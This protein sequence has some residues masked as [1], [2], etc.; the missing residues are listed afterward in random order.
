MMNNVVA[1]F[2]K[3]ERYFELSLC[4]VELDV[5]LPR[6]GCKLLKTLLNKFC[7]QVGEEIR[8]TDLLDG[9]I[10]LLYILF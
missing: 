9:V 8:L 10:V 4:C 7:R 2:P 3:F 5:I 6:R 1:F